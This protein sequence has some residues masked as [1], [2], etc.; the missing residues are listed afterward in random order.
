MAASSLTALRQRANALKPESSAERG[1]GAAGESLR[2]L[3]VEIG[4]RPESIAE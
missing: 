4:A 2:R 1:S 3:L